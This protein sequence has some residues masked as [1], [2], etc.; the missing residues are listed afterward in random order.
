MICLWT[1]HMLAPPTLMSRPNHAHSQTCLSEDSKNELTGEQTEE[2]K[3]A[4]DV[5]SSFASP[6][7]EANA[8]MK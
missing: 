5:A 1:L 6:S 3:M 2:T 7:G 4:D 8:R